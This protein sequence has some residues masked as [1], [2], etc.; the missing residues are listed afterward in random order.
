MVCQCIFLK[1]IWNDEFLTFHPD[2]LPFPAANA[3]VLALF[4]L[5][6]DALSSLKILANDYII[7]VSFCA[8]LDSINA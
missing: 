8:A 5:I 4:G 6:R 1:T 7:V 2:P 3:S